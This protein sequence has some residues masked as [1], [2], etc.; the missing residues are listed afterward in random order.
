[1][2][3]IFQAI[4][5]YL[6]LFDYRIKS[7]V[8]SSSIKLASGL[9]CVFIYLL[10]KRKIPADIAFPEEISFVTTMVISIVGIFPAQERLLSYF[11]SKFLSEYLSDDRLSARIAHKRFDADSLIRNV[12]PDMVKIANSPSGRLAILNKSETSYDIYSYS[13]GRQRKVKIRG[14]NINTRL[15]NL[16]KMK[17]QSISITDVME[18]PELNEDFTALKSNFIMPFIF[19][20]KLF[21]F[22]ATTNIPS[23]K[24]KA[25]LFFLASKAALAVHNHI[26][27]F[28]VAENKKYKREFEAAERIQFSI[29]STKVPEVP[30]LV[31]QLLEKDHR[32]L[33]EFYT[34]ESGGVIFVIFALPSNRKSEG[35]VL[36]YI[37][38]A[39]YIH[40]RSFKNNLNE[41]KLSVENTLKEIYYTDPYELLIGYAE[42]NKNLLQILASSRG[43]TASK[44][45]SPDKNLISLGWRNLLD[46]E[47]TP[48]LFKLKDKNILLV[49]KR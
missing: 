39:L 19:R 37:A 18:T 46:L 42:A 34:P 7:V 1:M 29:Q 35:L 31:I 25:D 33:S 21:G 30:G 8:I 41:I 3:A 17:K 20:E 26:L 47:S 43:I 13:R 6:S 14:E 44:L 10:I 36:A 49:G 11:R 23:E 24:S 38:G 27:S 16:L 15:T 32:L 5:Q 9:I 2:K 12:F 4:I 40:L 45:D 48:I 22:L 28:K